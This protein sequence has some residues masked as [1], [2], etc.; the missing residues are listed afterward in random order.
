MQVL[1]VYDCHGCDATLR[2]TAHDPMDADWHANK[3]GWEHNA[4]WD[5]WWCPDCDGDNA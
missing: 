1:V 2:I 5:V 3:R 4:T